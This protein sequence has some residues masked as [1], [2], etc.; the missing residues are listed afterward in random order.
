MFIVFEGIDGSGKTTQAKALSA[1]LTSKGIKH[2]CFVE[3]GST[4]VGYAIRDLLLGESAIP[5][6]PLTAAFL[7]CAARAELASKISLALDLG[8]VVICDRWSPSSFA[9]QGSEI[10]PSTIKGLDDIAR[11]GL[12]PDLCF[13]LDCP[14][15]DRY[16]VVGGAL[17]K[18]KGSDF[19]A[20]VSGYYANLDGPGIIHI[21]GSLT[22]YQVA[23]EVL[24]R[25]VESGHF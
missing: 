5:A 24:D 19:R 20:A 16:K 11:N 8:Y 2:A 3:P 6:E 18:D 17:C 13:I 15:S 23:S 25:M 21:D 22:V 9:Y 14:N 12:D 4:E 1:E 10:A 7:F